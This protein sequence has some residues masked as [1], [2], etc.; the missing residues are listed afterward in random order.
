MTRPDRVAQTSL[1]GLVL[2]HA[3]NVTTGVERV[4][5]AHPVAV[6]E[7]ADHFLQQIPAPMAEPDHF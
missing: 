7:P 3:H 1:S 6:P 5:Q 2:H 4:W